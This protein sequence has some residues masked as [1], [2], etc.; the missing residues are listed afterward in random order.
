MLINILIIFFLG[1]TIIQIILANFSFPLIEGLET[2]QSKITNQNTVQATTSMTLG[3]AP[4]PQTI[5]TPVPSPGQVQTPQPIPTISQQNA[6]TNA[7]DPLILSKTNASDISFLKEQV[8]YLLGL[9][10]QVQDMDQNITN[11]SQVVNGLVNQNQALA[12]SVVAS[13]K[14]VEI[15]GIGNEAFGNMFSNHN[16]YIYSLWK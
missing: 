9:N 7:S 10:S 5:S 16:N 8:N 6:G 2:Q 1:L 4:K 11:L 12:D 3:E 14:P 15:T 13:Q